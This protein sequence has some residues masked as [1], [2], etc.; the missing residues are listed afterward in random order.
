MKKNYQIKSVQQLIDYKTKRLEYT[1]IPY[2]RE[3]LLKDIV[4][5]EQIENL[6]SSEKKEKHQ[7]E[8]DYAE[9]S[10]ENDRLKLVLKLHRLSD[11]EIFYYSIMPYEKLLRL[12][13]RALF[14][15]EYKIPQAFQTTKKSTDA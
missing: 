9:L 6:F 4:D 7:L 14:L 5:L 15:G 8:Q 3:V 12:A 13:K 11:D 2:L 10:A 1:R